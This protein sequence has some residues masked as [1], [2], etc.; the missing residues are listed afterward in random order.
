LLKIGLLPPPPPGLPHN[1]LI[2][3]PP[4]HPEP[5]KGVRGGERDY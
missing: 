1:S 2:P 4:P 3:L 5:P